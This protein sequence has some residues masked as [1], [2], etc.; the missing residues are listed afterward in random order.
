MINGK[1]RLFCLP[2]AGGSASIY[3]KWKPY[4]T[5]DIELFAVELAGRGK[6]VYHPLYNSID[7]AAADVYRIISAELNGSPFG[8]F[9]H[10]L[11]SLIAFELAHRLKE[12]EH[13]PACVFFSGRGAPHVPRGEDKELYHTLPDNEFREKI[14]ELGGTPKEFFDHPELL[15]VFLPMLK[16]DFRIAET[17]ESSEEV[18]PLDYNIN[19][20]VGKEEDT[21]AEQIHG[22]KEHTNKVCSIHY[23][24]G[25]HFFFNEETENAAAII[26]RT[27]KECKQAA[28]SFI[29]NPAVN[30]AVRYLQ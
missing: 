1:F 12:T 15:E 10:S 21:T 16:N 14:L 24:P 26:N 17:Y 30:Y 25:G 2:Y 7:E 9:G 19:V 29:E 8:L 4:L 28:D 3:N 5:D 20:L 22:W 23:V 27:V 11:G 6:R 13:Q 18:E